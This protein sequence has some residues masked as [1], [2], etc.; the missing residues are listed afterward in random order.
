MSS[1]PMDTFKPKAIVFDLL[2]GLLDSWKIWDKS[3]P[4]GERSIADGLTW[5]KKYLEITYGVNA[6]VPYE[7]LVHQAAKEVGLSPAAPLALIEHIDEILPWPEVPPILW[8]LK[9]Q[10]LR[11]A[12]VTNC[13][14]ILA[15]RIIKNVERVCDQVEPNFKF[16]IVVTAEESGF[17][18]PNPKPY[19]DALKMLGV[20]AS[21]ALFVA[22]SS[23]DIP[24]ASN[25]GMQ[26]VWNNHIG[27]ERKNE[28][29]PLRE[30]KDL[31]AALGDI[32]QD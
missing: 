25:V 30:G 6:Y 10:G 11:L 12:V 28:V 23:S 20:E 19:K 1:T 7:D 22:G 16:D 26:V 29:L 2:T 4:D 31:R 14:K 3:V 15:S 32:L 9:K 8:Q 13:S 21:D 17:Y 5:R 27:L 18:K 24:G